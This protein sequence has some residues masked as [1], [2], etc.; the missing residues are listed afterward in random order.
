[1]PRRIT[2]PNVRKAAIRATVEHVFAHQKQ[3]MGLFVRTIGLPRPDTKIGTVNLAYNFQRLI[4][5]QRRA[6]TA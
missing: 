6:A 1:M 2:Q 3:H 4:F 5:Y